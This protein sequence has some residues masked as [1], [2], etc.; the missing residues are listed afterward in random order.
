VPCCTTTLLQSSRQHLPGLMQ[1]TTVAPSAA[2]VQGTTG[3]LN[4]PS[5]ALHMAD[6]NTGSHCNLQHR[7]SHL[8][9]GLPDNS[10]IQV[11]SIKY[12]TIHTVQVATTT[13][14]LHKQLVPRHT[15]LCC[16]LE[17]WNRSA[18]P[19][20][21]QRS[22][23]TTAGQPPSSCAIHRGVPGTGQSPSVTTQNCD[24]CRVR[25]APNM[26]PACNPA[27]TQRAPNMH[28]ACTPMQKL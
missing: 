27:C 13:D 1:Q 17:H 10:T 19:H 3:T 2:P 20:H 9:G 14:N 16:C 25:P 6:S 21:L 7:C 15:V 5:P 28:P 22:C 18:A 11:L 12:C 23:C 26:H 4:A 8:T 24:H